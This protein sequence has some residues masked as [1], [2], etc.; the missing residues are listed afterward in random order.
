MKKK[1]Y[2]F[3]EYISSQKNGIGSFLGEFLDC[4]KQIDV[5]LCVLV[6]NANVE[7]F[8]ITKEGEVEKMLFPPFLIGDFVHNADI[9]DKF[10]RL[11]IPDAPRNV[12]FINHSPCGQLLRAIKSSHPLSRL[13]FTIHDLGWT[14][15]Y[16]GDEDKFKRAVL[17]EKQTD[18]SESSKHIEEAYAEEKEIYKLADRVVCLNRDT[19]GLLLDTYFVSPEKIVLIPNGLRQLKNASL[20]SGSSE[21]RQKLFVSEEDKIL[22]FAGR[23]TP[24]KGMYA[25]LEAFERVLQVERNAR[26]VIAG[27][28]NGVN[29][30]GLIT[31]ASRFASRVVFTGLIDRA[32]LN[33]W[34]S[35]A[36]V[37]IIPS[38]YEQCPYTGIEMMMHGLPVVAS[39]SFGLRSMFIEGVNAKVA[40]I[41][42]RENL[43]EFVQHIADAILKLLASEELC[44][45]LS[46]GA[47]S[48]YQSTYH[49]CHMVK[50]YVCLLDSLSSDL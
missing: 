34:Y 25:L 22:L 40:R 14:S 35:V 15:L 16:W 31:I 45:E 36:D 28:D 11:Y 18:G 26:L 42:N 12:F 46:A 2:V 17:K 24:K 49:A 1:V 33:E 19:Y 20:A 8:T 48:I 38:F 5:D 29:M 10:F 7:E 44:E 21:L 6:F 37:G 13:V 32:R 23:P 27:F 30:E 50:K 47:E 39:D 9:I 43:N 41:G 3:D 4:M